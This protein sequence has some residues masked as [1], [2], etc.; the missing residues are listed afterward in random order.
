MDKEQIEIKSYEIKKTK[1]G[2]EIP[3]INGVHL[4]SAYNPQKESLNLVEKY[5]SQL[6]DK[7]TLLVLG[8]GFGYHIEALLKRMSEIHG[9]DFEI[10]V[11][12]PCLETVENLKRINPELLTKI[13]VFIGPDIESHYQNKALIRFLI[14]KPL[15]VPHTSTFNLFNRFFKSFMTYQAPTTIAACREVLTNQKLINYFSN[16]PS[17][18]NFSEIPNE[19]KKRQTPITDTTDFLILAFDEMT[20]SKTE[21]SRVTI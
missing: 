13:H 8:L 2:L 11:L 7:A 18:M 3:V 19:I 1:N 9:K 16:F 21:K 4:H 10:A 20:R 6:H 12:E 14:N 5:E 15:I 17:E